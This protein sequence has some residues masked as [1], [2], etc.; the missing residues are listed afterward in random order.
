MAA[1]FAAGNLSTPKPYRDAFLLAGIFI[2]ASAVPAFWLFTKKSM[3]Q[4]A[5]TQQQ[6]QAYMRAQ[7][8][9]AQAAATSPEGSATADRS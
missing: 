2:A 7:A 3:A 8:A 5:E 6:I 1:V 9:A 4:I